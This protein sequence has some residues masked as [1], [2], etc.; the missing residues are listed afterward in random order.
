MACFSRLVQL[1]LVPQLSFNTILNYTTFSSAGLS[2]L[3]S[4]F[5]QSLLSFEHIHSQ[6]SSQGLIS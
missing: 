4:A 2:V 5:N 6:R 3:A 1:R